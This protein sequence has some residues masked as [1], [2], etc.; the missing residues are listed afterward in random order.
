MLSPKRKKKSEVI[1]LDTPP[2]SLTD[3]AYGFILDKILR[4][5]L[6]MGA[7]INRRRLAD[8]L[9]MSVLPISEALQRLEREML[10][11][12]GK[13]VGTR[14][15]IPTPQDIRGFCVVREALET[16]AA[17]MFAQRARPSQHE[18]LLERA[19]V[20][21]AAYEASTERGEAASDDDLHRLRMLHRSFHLKI[22]EYT[23]CPYLC[24]Q[25]ERNQNLVF[26]SF[27]DKLFGNR[28]LPPE[29]HAG[30]ARVLASGDPDAADR[31]TREHVRHHLDEILYRLEPYFSLDRDLLYKNVE[32]S[33]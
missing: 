31:A 11:E 5:N 3:A 25:V 13:R 28:R 6:P 21:D 33:N 4:G 18:E 20:L 15:R 14:V 12:S 22:A 10:V 2:V 1:P 30:L 27:Y 29:W 24:Q 16:Q 9:N 32:K 23:A 7:E 19:R 26:N 17:R 8:E